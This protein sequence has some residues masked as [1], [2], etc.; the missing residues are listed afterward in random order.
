M[1]SF[2]ILCVA[3]LA[4]SCNDH[5]QP[6]KSGDTTTVINT[7]TGNVNDGGPNQGMGDT[8]A[9]NMG[10]VDTGSIKQAPHK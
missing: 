1:K 2:F 9:K 10:T 3:A 7:Q 4:F 5:S 6:A 8:T